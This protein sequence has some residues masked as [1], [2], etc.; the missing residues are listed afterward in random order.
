MV[1]ICNTVPKIWCTQY[2]ALHFQMSHWN[3]AYAI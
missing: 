1:S 3:L 2:E